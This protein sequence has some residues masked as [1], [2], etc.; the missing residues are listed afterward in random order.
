MKL[1]DNPKYLKMPHT[2]QAQTSIPPVALVD[3]GSDLSLSIGF[4]DY[5]T[6]PFLE[7]EK[8]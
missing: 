5:L 7:C 3:Q 1:L 8:E 6:K 4:V 2:L